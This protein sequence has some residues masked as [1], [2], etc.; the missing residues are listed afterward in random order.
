MGFF[1]KGSREEQ[2]FWRVPPLRTTDAQ[3]LYQYG[4]QTVMREDH[5][6]TIATG[7]SLWGLVGMAEL[8]TNDFVSDGYSGWRSTTSFDPSVGRKFLL[9]YFNRARETANT[10][11]GGHL[12]RVNV[13]ALPQ[14]EVIP[15]SV[16]YGAMCFAGNELVVI[17][18]SIGSTSGLAE[19]SQE[20]FQSVAGSNVVFVPPRTLGWARS[21][22]QNK[23]LPDPWPQ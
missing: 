20:V 22:A 6:A 7:W 2:D 16:A 17:S 21:Y 5:K 23:G 19:Q 9:D 4:I 14:D 12:A 11:D 18:E 10:S 8:Q 3:V 1:K 15:V 13:W